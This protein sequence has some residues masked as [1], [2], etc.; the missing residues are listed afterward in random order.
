M[1][2]GQDLA[3][4]A[5]VSLSGNAYATLSMVAWAAGFPAAELLLDTWD[6]LAMVLGRFLMAMALILPLWWLTGGHARSRELRWARGL[7]VGGIGFGGGAWAILMS[8]WYTD[9]VTVAIIAATTPLAATL[10][11]W[12]YDRQPLTRGF[13]LGLVATLAGGLIAT[14]VGSGQ[15]LPADLGPGA[16]MAVISALLF[17]WGSHHIV[18]DLPDSDALTRTVVSSLGA[19]GFIVVA[20]VA[21]LA[22]GLS[23]LP[24]L[25]MT[26]TDL[27]LLA[28]YGILAFGVSQFAWIAA[29]DKLG[30]A[31]AAFHINVAPFYVMLI[32]LAL[33]GAWSWPQAIGAAIVGAGVI[34]AQRR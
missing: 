30:V 24:P 21:F 5:P 27:G 3:P 26:G 18:R 32:L 13:S 1:T 34:L 16:L 19:T 28:I 20:Y 12:W 4:R 25:P 29:A 11:A 23:A 22:L 9:P 6:P 33:G 14:G 15:P 17:S 31:I 2:D 7:W 8:Q 10:V